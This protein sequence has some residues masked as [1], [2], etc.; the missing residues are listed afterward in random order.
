MRIRSLSSFL[1]ATQLHYSHRNYIK[2]ISVNTSNKFLH[3]NER[4]HCKSADAAINTH[5]NN[6]L[7]AENNP[8]QTVFPPV[9]L[10]FV[11]NCSTKIFLRKRLSLF[12]FLSLNDGIYLLAKDLYQQQETRSSRMRVSVRV[13][14]SE[15]VPRQSKNCLCFAA[16]AWN[17]NRCCSRGIPDTEDTVNN[18]VIWLCSTQSQIVTGLLTVNHQIKLAIMFFLW[19][20]V[21]CFD[22]SFGDI[23]HRDVCLPLQT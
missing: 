1:C 14:K 17:F 5:S 9:L 11:Q 18:P 8:K 10:I 6:K 13:G 19:P 23:S 2:H 21:E 4:G 22:V 3:Y 12:F 16:L 20:A 7:A 15:N